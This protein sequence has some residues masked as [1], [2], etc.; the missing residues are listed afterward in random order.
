MNDF[1]DEHGKC[2]AI[3]ANRI[4]ICSELMRNAHPCTKKSTINGSSMGKICID[5]TQIVPS[6]PKAIPANSNV[7]TLLRLLLKD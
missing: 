4:V 2:T 1:L 5:I 6:P 3:S 7:D